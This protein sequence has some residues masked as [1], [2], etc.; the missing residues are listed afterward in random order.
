MDRREKL[1]YSF[2]YGMKSGFCHGPVSPTKSVQSSPPRP[3]PGRLEVGPEDPS[4]GSTASFSASSAD[5]KNS[6]SLKER[7]SMSRQERSLL[8]PT[9]P[10]HVHRSVERLHGAAATEEDRPYTCEQHASPTLSSRSCRSSRSR[11]VGGHDADEFMA[12]VM[13]V[14][15]PVKKSPRKRTTTTTTNPVVASGVPQP[16]QPAPNM[17]RSRSGR[18]LSPACG[19]TPARS[20]SPKQRY[21]PLPRKSSMQFLSDETADATSSSTTSS[22]PRRCRSAGAVQCLISKVI[23]KQ[24]VSKSLG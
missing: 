7:S 6:K 23:Q 13:V 12:S 20:K 1:A 9:K 21:R 15:S 24:Q 17:V 5:S 18:E 14:L 10:S 16:H 11:S 4:I 19:S 8:T 3:S 2:D 22:S